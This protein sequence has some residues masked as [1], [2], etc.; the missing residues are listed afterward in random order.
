MKHWIGAVLRNNFLYVAESIKDVQ[1]ISL[2]QIIET[3]PLPEDHFLYRQL[4]KGG[5]KKDSFSTA[6]T[7]LP[8]PTVLHST[9]TISSLSPGC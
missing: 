9:Q 8:K 5:A 4:K 2:R 7:Y 1:G 6:P 3:L